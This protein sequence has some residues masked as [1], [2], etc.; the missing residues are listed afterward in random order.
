[1]GIFMGFLPLPVVGI[2]LA[3]LLAWVLGAN[4]VVVIPL[5]FVTN[6]LTVVP[7]YVLSYWLGCWVLGLPIQSIPWEILFERLP[8][9]Q[10]VMVFYRVGLSFYLPIFVGSTIIGGLLGVVSYGPVRWMLE[11]RRRR[12]HRS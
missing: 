6:P 12:I 11:R 2:P 4:R 10:R 5:L 8:F 7:V 3:I 9:W 1:M